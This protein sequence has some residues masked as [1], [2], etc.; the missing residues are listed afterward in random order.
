MQKEIV[1]RFAPSPTGF[2][3]VGGARTALFNYLFSRKLGGEFK[4]RIE[5]T[6]RER[7]SEE[8]TRQIF[9]GLRWLGV[10]WDGEVVFQGANA[11]EHV[12]A[13]GS[14]VEKDLAYRCF[15]TKEELEEKRKIAEAN[16]LEYGYDGTC[17]NLS[18]EQIADNLKAHLP[19]SIRFRMPGGETGWDDA[20]YGPITIKNSE[21]DDFIILR[22]DGSP[23]YH[24]AV[25]VDDHN[26]GITNVIRGGDHVSNTP[27]QILLYRAFGWDV[28]LFA[29]VPLILGPDKKRL[30]KRHGATSVDEYRR[31]GFL[32]EAVFNYLTLLG[33][34]PGDD[35]EVMSKEELIAAFSLEGITKANA[36]FDE[37]KL[38]WMNGEY[39]SVKSAS[40]LYTLVR[41]LWQEAGF[42]TSG[43]A[44]GNPDRLLDIIELLKS[45]MK[46][47]GDFVRY[48]FYYFKDPDTYES[49]GIRKYFKDDNSWQL[50]DELGNRFEKLNGFDAPQIEKTLRDLAEER[51]VSAGAIIHPLRLAL[52]GMTVSPG[53]FEVAE[54]LGRKTTVRRLRSL[55][56]N[57]SSILEFAGSQ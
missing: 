11:T 54:I 51:E 25:V 22:S 55:L 40:E 23:I 49:K 28:P 57:R 1:T 16:K 47:L 15:C 35:R 32:P 29:H 18:Q 44:D 7:S 45:R 31:S 19:F 21:L 13:A 38:Q 5:D 37:K 56:D 8:M 41:P 48:G 46:T 36:V 27:K 34:S 53:L 33:W 6:D 42:L 50:L 3:H 20:V 10:S 17:R 24:L 52:T 12:K 2:L 9:E 39:I 43:M 4:L 14:L 26:M 30:S